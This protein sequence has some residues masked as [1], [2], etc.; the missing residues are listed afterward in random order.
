MSLW[1]SSQTVAVHTTA[2]TD[3]D[4]ET[5]FVG[6]E[7]LESEN[8]RLFHSDVWSD[9]RIYLDCLQVGHLL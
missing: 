2:I 9:H 1:L 4:K 3:E 5:R 8:S 7:E 6:D